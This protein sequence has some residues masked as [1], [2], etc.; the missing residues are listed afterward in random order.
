[1][2]GCRDLEVHAFKQRLAEVEQANTNV[3]QHIFYDTVETAAPNTY[4]G[5]VELAQLEEDIVSQE[6][7]YYICGPRGFI[8][9]HYQYLV[10]QKVDKAAIF[11]E[12][13]GPAS[14]TL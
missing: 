4:T 3:T 1:M 13:F 12:E 11:F 2:H 6:A 5:W 14:L 10:D 8:E 9:K 7:E